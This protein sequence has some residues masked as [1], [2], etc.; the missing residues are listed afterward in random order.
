MKSAPPNRVKVRIGPRQYTINCAPEDEEKVLKF[1]SL[2]DENYQKLGTARAAQE[3]DNMVFAALFMADEL[4]E[5]RKR[6]SDAKIEIAELRQQ[7][8]LAQDDAANALKQAKTRSEQDKERSGGKKAELRSEIETLRKA[9]ERARRENTK[10][11]AEIAELQARAR[12]Q[13]DLF[14]GPAEDAALSDAI[15]EKLEEL[16]VKAEATASELEARSQVS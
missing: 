14:G 10:L 12:H 9:E 4:D 13:H 1:G 2:I 6:A 7:L 11:K 3:A 15:A 5:A 16:A 8:Q